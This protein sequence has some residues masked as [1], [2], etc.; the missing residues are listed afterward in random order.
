MVSHI[1]L[2]YI[3]FKIYVYVYIYIIKKKKKKKK[4]LGAIVC[5]TYFISSKGHSSQSSLV[6]LDLP[7]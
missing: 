6:E 2:A 7:D 5:P 3:Q 1:Y 4:L